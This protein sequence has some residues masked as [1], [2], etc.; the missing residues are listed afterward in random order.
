MEYVAFIYSQCIGRR[1]SF[2]SFVKMKLPSPEDVRLKDPRVTSRENRAIDWDLVDVFL[3]VI[4]DSGSLSLLAR[5]VAISRAA[6]AQRRKELRLGSLPA[7]RQKTVKLTPLEEEVAKELRV[8]AG[9]F[10][11]V[12]HIAAQRG[13]SYGAIAS[14]ARRIE[15]KTANR[16]ELGCRECGG[17]GIVAC[18]TCLGIG[19]HHH[20]CLA[21]GGNSTTWASQGMD[22]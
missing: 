7:G 22:K 18:N 8:W 20:V 3:R 13:V 2:S 17:L 1:A 9:S 12:G 6:L 16:L 15:W 21:C 4:K 10:K 11:G 19:P 5:A 14:V